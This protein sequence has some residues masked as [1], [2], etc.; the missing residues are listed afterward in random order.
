MPK[1]DDMYCPTCGQVIQFEPCLCNEDDDDKFCP[2]CLLPFNECECG[3]EEDDDIEPR[4][5]F[6]GKLISQCDCTL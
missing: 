4:C 5:R 2:D 3:Y 1:E 6:C